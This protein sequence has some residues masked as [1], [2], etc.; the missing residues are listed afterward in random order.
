MILAEIGF[1]VSELCALEWAQGERLLQTASVNG[2]ELLLNGRAPKAGEIMKMPYLAQTLRE[3]G[4]YGRD[5]F[6]KG[7]IGQEIV[8]IIE[9]TGGL[10]SL[11]D[12]RGHESTQDPVITTN[13]R[14]LDIF[15]MPPN[16]QGI[17]AL[18]ALNILEGFD[19]SEVEH[20]SAQ[21]LHYVIESLRLAFA[22]ANS[23][24]GDPNFVPSIPIQ[25]MLSKRYAAER[26]KLINPQTAIPKIQHGYPLKS[27]STVYFCVV[28]AYGNACSFINSNYEGFGT[29]IVPQRCGFTLH[30][31][32]ANF[33]LDRNSPNALHPGKR[34]FHTIIPGMALQDGELFGPFG[35]VRGS[36][37]PQG[38]LQILSNLV[39]FGMNPQEALDAPRVQIDEGNSEGRILLED[40]IPS[41]VKDKLKSMGHH[42]PMYVRGYDRMYFGN[43]QIITRDTESGVCCAGSDPRG[44]GHAVPVIGNFVLK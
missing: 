21:H 34:P 42:S 16:G 5:G 1:P 26:R 38:H 39:D 31:R 8:S 4:G 3:L 25:E 37:Q 2:G 20:N 36:M 13:Y 7:R 27:S 12:L 19:L 15:E 29:G 44:D 40:G 22:D 41:Q 32:G 33:S 43:G 17:T 18:L 30:N 14:G 11:D 9:Q 35:V 23:F 28:D 24:I 6:Y 10:M